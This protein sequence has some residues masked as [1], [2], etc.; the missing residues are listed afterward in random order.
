[1]MELFLG[2]HKC[3]LLEEEVTKSFYSF[4]SSKYNIITDLFLP[5]DLTQDWNP[6]RLA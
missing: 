6:V 1:M 2:Y 3:Y 5:S 4:W